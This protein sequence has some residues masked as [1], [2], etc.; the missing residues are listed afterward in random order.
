LLFLKF[1][2]NGTFGGE[3]VFIKKES[4]F[5]VKESF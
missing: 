3:L 1:P 2:I 5:N 4:F